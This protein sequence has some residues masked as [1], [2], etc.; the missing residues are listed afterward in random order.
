M[1]KQ[2]IKEI[3]KELLD[4]IYSKLKVPE[5]YSL[6]Y[7]KDM[8][9]FVKKAIKFTIKELK[10]NGDIKEF[11]WREDK[12]LALLLTGNITNNEFLERRKKLIGDKL[13]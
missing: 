7:Y 6:D 4:K 13:I 3:E 9:K 5:K 1:N 2:E 12:L 10:Q 8:R 11:I